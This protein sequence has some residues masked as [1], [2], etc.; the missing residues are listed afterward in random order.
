MNKKKILAII[1]I[2]ILLV[3]GG[4]FMFKRYVTIG[5]KQLDKSEETI[6]DLFYS[7]MLT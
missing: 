4:Y 2:L 7:S 6:I 5:V 3:V 1:L